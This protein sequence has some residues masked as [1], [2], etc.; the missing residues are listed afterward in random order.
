[1]GSPQFLHEIVERFAADAGGALAVIDGETRWS[2]AALWTRVGVWAERVGAVVDSAGEGGSRVGSEPGLAVGVLAENSVDLLA[3]QLAIPMAGASAFLLNTRLSDA[4]LES[5]V[6]EVRPVAM[7]SSLAQADRGD[8]LAA[9]VAA[10]AMLTG[11]VAASGPAIGTAR[12][13]AKSELCP[14]APAWIIHTSGTTGRPKGALL[15]HEGLLAAVSVTAAARP[16]ADDDVYLFP[17]PLF[18]VAAY[19]VLHALSRRRPVV[20]VPKFDAVEV[21]SAIESERVT[22]MSLAPTMISM[23]LDHPDRSRFDLSSLRM[24]AY[25]A[26]AIPVETLRRGLGEL[27]CD[28]AQGYGMTELSGN[29]VFLGPE[30]HRLAA[31]A[32]PDLLAAAGTP[33]PG[34]EIRLV[35]DDGAECGPGE[36]GEIEI[37]SPQRFLGYFDNAEA[38]AAV[39]TTDGWLRTGDIGR[40]DTEGYLFVVDRKKDLI[41]SGGENISSREVEDVVSEFPGVAQCAAVGLPDERWG[42][43][44]T[45]V[46]VT[47]QRAD[48]VGQDLIAFCRERLAGFKCPKRVVIVDALPVNASGKVQKNVLRDLLA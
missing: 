10:T 34:V 20:L 35:N 42:E 48:V 18:H 29:A 13:R 32:R 31:G 12:I 21:M 24:I 27:N 22:A 2:A 17:F 9:A 39:L 47:Q 40:V 33:G 28:F 6:A 11:D 30:D 5:L 38:T 36:R 45:A 37:R 44:V 4:E 8:R 19:N 25:G 3:L 14:N 41:I 46:V 26:S 1:V 23:L 16:L 43:V 15:S 7:V